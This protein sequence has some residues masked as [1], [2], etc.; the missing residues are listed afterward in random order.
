MKKIVI[1]I[2][3]LGTLSA[4]ANTITPPFNIAARTKSFAIPSG[5]KPIDASPSNA[6][7]LCHKNKYTKLLSY[8]TA[9]NNGI[10]AQLNIDGSIIEELSYSVD[11]ITSVECSIEFN[12]SPGGMNVK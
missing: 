6:L 5:G 4:M 12:D 8:Q 1:T 9:P 11:K 2:I 7:F 10:A 3:T